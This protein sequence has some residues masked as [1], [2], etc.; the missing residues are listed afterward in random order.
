MQ[1]L[2]QTAADRTRR[3]GKIPDVRP[4]DGC[5]H[6]EKCRGRVVASISVVAKTP[7]WPRSNDPVQAFIGVQSKSAKCNSLCP[8]N[9]V[10]QVKLRAAEGVK[11][12]VY[13][14]MLLSHGVLFR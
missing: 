14:S 8:A 6:N 2:S 7:T 3:W 9:D 1:A 13:R 5:G 12:D 4:L 11:H 10:G